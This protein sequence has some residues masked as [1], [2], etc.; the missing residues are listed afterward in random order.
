[1]E[2]NGLKKGLLFTSDPYSNIID[3]NDKNTDM[4]F[5]DGATATFLTENSVF[6]VRKGIFGTDGSRFDYL[7]KRNNDWL[8]MNG[9]G[10]F[11]FTMKEVPGIVDKCLETNG[12]KKENIDLFLLHQASKYIVDNLCRRIKLQPEKTPFSAE[13]YGNTI[14]SSIPMLLKDHMEDP[15]KINIL[16]CGFGVG[17]SVASSILRRK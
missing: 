12:L 1:M 10:I 17:L 9:R 16:I 7:I 3:T 6:E 8:V 14:S 4:L 11:E 13:A 2:S 15:T 5:G